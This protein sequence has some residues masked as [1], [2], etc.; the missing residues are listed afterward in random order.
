MG[1][2]D[3]IQGPEDLQGLNEREMAA[4]ADEIRSFLIKTVSETGGH[5]ASNL[6]AV[7]LTLAIHRVFHSP[8]DPIV[9]DVGHQ[10]YTHKILTGRRA[11]MGTLRKYGGLSGFPKPRES[12][13]DA[14]IAGH[15]STSISAA[16]GMAEAI[17]SKGRKNHAIAVIGDGSL[18]GGMAYEAL[19]N[20]GKTQL[21]LIVVLNDNGMAI[22]KNVGAVAAGLTKMRTSR[23]YFHAKDRTH[24][25]LRRIPWIG[26]ALDRGISRFVHKVKMLFYGSN[27]FE[28]LGLV[29][30]GPVDGHDLNA[31]QVLLERAKQ[32]N[33]PCLV[34]AVTVKGKGFAAAEKDPIG[35]HGTP[36]FDKVTGKQSLSQTPDFS[37]MMGEALC[38]KAAWDPLL[39]VITAAMTDG[40]GLRDFSQQYP[41]RFFDVGIA[42]EHAATF[43]AALAASGLHPVFCVYSTFLQR[44]ADQMIHD[45]GLTGEKVVFCVDR[46]GVVGADGE[47]HQGIHD[48]PLLRSAGFT[49]LAPADFDELKQSLTLALQ[50]IPG[51][52]A[53]RYPRGEEEGKSRCDMKSSF[54]F[55]QKKTGADSV[56]VTHG[57]YLFTAMK[58]LA[59][60][61][62][63]ICKLNWLSPIVPDLIAALRGYRDVIYVAEEAQDGCLGEEIAALLSPFRVRT[64]IL[65]LPNI[66]EHGSREELLHKYGMDA[67]GL[68]DFY[69]KECL[70]GREKTPGS[71][72]L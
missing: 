67:S 71:S 51:A 31:L 62:V 4:L 46:A 57:T 56:L 27:L 9:F 59:E 34:H 32:L 18:T 23:R 8:D 30:L 43:S 6:G 37:A 55:Q 63:D 36:I 24:R 3:R 45:I 66:V 54:A 40:C 58:A 15:A 72:G 7:E 11:E 68:K 60:E 53:I 52:V 16:L 42:E 20:A 12:C 28:E 64:H 65:A 35:F 38:E 69:R 1:Y 21:P 26:S 25:L 48:V 39:R 33:R 2:L 47:T 22:S 14:F 17:Q 10:A 44:C 61:P 70:Y 29:Y 13:H 19:C 49:V 50:Q 5:L 41:D